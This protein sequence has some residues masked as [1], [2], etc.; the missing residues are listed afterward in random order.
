VKALIDGDI[1]VY[2]VA[3][4]EKG[5]VPAVRYL[6]NKHISDIRDATQCSQYQIYLSGSDNF[7]KDLDPSYKAQRVLEKPQYFLEARDYL[8]R[9]KGAI[10]SKGCEAD[11][12]LGVNQTDNTVICSIDKDL[13]QIPGRHYSWPIKHGEK[14]VREAMH[15]KTTYIEGLKLFYKQML[16]GDTVDNIKC[17]NG[18]GPKTAAKLIDTLES[19][20]DMIAVV[21]QLY[22]ENEI[23]EKFNINA[24]LIWIWRS[25]GETYTVRQ[26]TKE[27]A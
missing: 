16:T 20:D 3:G 9:S 13:L 14:V 8:V 24:D 1:L 7:R 5:G 10:V 19:E 2:R 23:L 26:E 25:L 15:R 27:T 11:D 4:I 21:H 12:L 22:E 18:C 6:L 17:I